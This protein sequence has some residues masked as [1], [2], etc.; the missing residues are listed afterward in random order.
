MEA[1][2]PPG[3]Q[4][5]PAF[6]EAR[7]CPRFPLHTDIRVYS[8]SAGLLKG[9]TVDISE[10]GISAMLKLDLSIGEMV[11]LECELPSGP[12]AILAVV[13]HQTAFRYGFEFLESDSQGVIK[14]TCS[15]LA[16]LQ[17]SHEDWTPGR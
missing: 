7:R 15:H 14:A 12:V 10:S 2:N 3:T 4:P 8:R 13:R 16:M 5:F 17:R 6:A 11:Q 9:Y 1:E